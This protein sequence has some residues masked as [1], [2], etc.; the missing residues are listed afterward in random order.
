[1]PGGQAA[2][3]HRLNGTDRDGILHIG[4]SGNLRRR[5]PE[6]YRAAKSG[7]G[8]HQAGNE[9][10]NWKF[11]KEFPLKSLRFDYVETGDRRQAVRLE[12]ALHQRY[13]QRFLDRPPLDGTSGQQ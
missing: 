11:R 1:M 8:N 9:F 13:R 3:I 10:Q 12:R 7:N 5:I 2:P 6:F 4:Q